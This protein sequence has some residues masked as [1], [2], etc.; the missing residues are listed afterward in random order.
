MF[1]AYQRASRP[2][3]RLV[4]DDFT[5]F[6]FLF[7]FFQNYNFN[8]LTPFL[9]DLLSIGNPLHLHFFLKAAAGATGAPMAGKQGVTAAALPMLVSVEAS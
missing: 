8:S 3:K 6:I 4:F 1:L 9:I 7:T 2:Y 5:F